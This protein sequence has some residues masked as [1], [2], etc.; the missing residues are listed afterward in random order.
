MKVL[1]VLPSLSYKLG[2]PTQAA[3][4][5]VRTLRHLDIDA[6]IAT[7]N[8]D[9]SAL[10]DVPTGQQIDYDGVPVWFFSRLARLK[11]FIPSIGLTQWMVN[12]L[13]KYDI[14]HTHYLFCYAPTLAAR[15]ARQRNIPYVSSTIGQLTPWALQQSQR[16]KQIYSRLI[17][18]PTLNRAAAIH[19]T[20]PAEAKDAHCFGVSA[21][22]LV[23]PLG[24]NPTLVIFDAAARLRDR[25]SLLPH[26]TVVLFLSRLHEKKRPDFLLRAF[27]QLN[28]KSHG[29]HLL[30]AG[31]GDAAYCDRL[32][33]LAQSLGIADSV[34]FTGFVSGSDKDLLLQGS[35]IF[36]LPSYSENFGIAVAEALA[37][38]LP[39]IITPEVQIAPD[40]AAAHAGLVVPGSLADW[41]AALSK[42]LSSKDWRLELGQNGQ[43]LAQTKYNWPAIAEQL[44]QAY[45]DILAGRPLSI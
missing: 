3:L 19:C 24:V 32:Q 11:A 8:D 36:A 4:N 40:I 31:S 30:L 1:H 37:A 9:E 14:V 34:T 7:T 33:A 13:N 12:N 15:L 16:K 43:R 6:E 28:P 20:T 2:G 21:P 45:G 39:V 38:T 41:T 18:R 35:D 29:Y 27:A 25:Y 17:E 42:L 22:A 26:C 5:T 23:L 44:A 10:L